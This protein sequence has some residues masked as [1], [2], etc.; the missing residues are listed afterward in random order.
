[1]ELGT[2]RTDEVDALLDNCAHIEPAEACGHTRHPTV[3][4]K[5]D[6]RGA[7]RGHKREVTLKTGKKSHSR[8][9]MMCKAESSD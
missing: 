2:W 9:T 3:W 5:R 7:R 4:R 8:H 6:A 1:M